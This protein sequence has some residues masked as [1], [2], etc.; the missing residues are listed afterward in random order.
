MSVNQDENT[1][2]IV[3]EGTQEGTEDDLKLIFFDTSSI[4]GEPMVE[5]TFIDSVIENTKKYDNYSIFRNLKK[6][7]SDKGLDMSGRAIW[8]LL[9]IVKQNNQKIGLLLGSLPESLHIIGCWPRVLADQLRGD[10][11]LIDHILENF[12]NNAEFWNQVDLIIGFQ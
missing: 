12:V 3:L 6:I 5:R 1:W 11:S 9:G 2:E 8:A 7:M 4:L 10:S